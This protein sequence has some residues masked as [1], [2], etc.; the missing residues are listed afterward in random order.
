VKN[1]NEHKNEKD[2]NREGKDAYSNLGGSNKGCWAIVLSWR[3]GIRG[4]VEM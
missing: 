1:P 3:G 2:G 4:R